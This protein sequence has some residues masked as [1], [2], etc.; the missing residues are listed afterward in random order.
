MD[1]PEEVQHSITEDSLGSADMPRIED[2]LGTPTMVFLTEALH[3]EV[4]PEE[5]ETPLESQSIL[6]NGAKETSNFNLSE[7]ED[8]LL[9]GEKEPVFNPMLILDCEEEEDDLEIG[10]WEKLKEKITRSVEAKDTSQDYV[11]DTH[12]DILK[13][14]S[15]MQVSNF[16]SSTN[17]GHSSRGFMSGSAQSFQ[18]TELEPARPQITDEPTKGHCKQDGYRSPPMSKTLQKYYIDAESFRNEMTRKQKH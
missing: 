12:I 6:E 13:T 14:D 3:E 9:L 11:I 15:Q 18:V 4:I 8:L 7:Q 10:E 16:M 17:G 1:I 2:S 5:A